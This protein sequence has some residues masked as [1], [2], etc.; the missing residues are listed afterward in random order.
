MFLVTI[1]DDYNLANFRLIMLLYI[2]RLTE[3]LVFTMLVFH[4]DC[5]EQVGGMNRG[6]VAAR[7][8]TETDEPKTTEQIA[9]LIDCIIVYNRHL[10]HGQKLT[11]HRPIAR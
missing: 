5:D 10:H 6:Q 3:L 8:A 4:T 1:T 2:H 9:S 7:N 11:S